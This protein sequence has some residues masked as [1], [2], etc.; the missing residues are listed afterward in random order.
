VI[1]VGTKPWRLGPL[2]PALMVLAPRRC[3]RTRL[4]AKPTR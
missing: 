2:P 1:I 4:R 3:L